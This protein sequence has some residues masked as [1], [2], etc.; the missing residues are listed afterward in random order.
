MTED[1]MRY[2]RMVE[3]AMRGVVR[4]ALQRVLAD[5]L[6]GE[7]HFYVTFRTGAPGVEVPAYLRE[8][9]PD[10]MTIVLQ[11]RFSDLE[12]G[13]SGFGVTLSFNE[14]PARLIVP[15]EAISAFADPS[16]RFGF[17]FASADEDALAEAQA[18]GQATDAPED[19]DPA[20]ASSDESEA[21]PGET[22]AAADGGETVVSLDRFRKNKS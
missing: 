19:G 1:L 14:V 17:T 21:T 22:A 4:Q 18:A 9:Y 3:E 6:P 15:Y 10:E 2:D 20:P 11:H 5:G 7:H 13:E 16:V 8:R 12:V